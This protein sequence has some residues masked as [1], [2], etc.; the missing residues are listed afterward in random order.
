MIENSGSR[1]IIT[2]AVKTVNNTVAR[3]P[4]FGVN[5]VPT[6]RRGKSIYSVMNNLRKQSR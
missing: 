6:V 4:N 2:K 1:N 5:F 3:I